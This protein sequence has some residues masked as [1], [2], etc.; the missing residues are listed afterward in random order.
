L[1]KT[2]VVIKSPSPALRDAV[3]GNDETISVTFDINIR[4]PLS[5]H[6]SDGDADLQNQCCSEL[7]KMNDGIM[8]M[9]RT[10]Q[11]GKL[12]LIPSSSITNILGY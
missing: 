3:L 5:C 8:K 7:V 4:G 1:E 11:N 9:N 6:T 10:T 2:E 12:H